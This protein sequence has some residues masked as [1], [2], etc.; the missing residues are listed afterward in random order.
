MDSVCID[1]QSIKE[2]NVQVSMMGQIFATA[3]RVVVWLGEEDEDTASAYKTI[4]HLATAGSI[5][6][7][8]NEATNHKAL[9]LFKL[10]VCELA[11]LQPV[12]RKD[13]QVMADLLQKA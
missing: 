1:Q 4:E 8:R 5:L 11:G 13:I 9:G 7:Q 6:A 2:K 10:Q 12:S 3:K